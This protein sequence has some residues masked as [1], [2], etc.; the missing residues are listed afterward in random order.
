MKKYLVGSI[1]GAII[2]FIWQGLSYMAL[3]VHSNDM[4]YTS[5]QD[6]IMPVLTANLKEDGAYEMPSAATMKERN[7]MMKSM[8]GKP[9]ATIIYKS[10]VSTD[11]TMRYVRCILLDIFLVIS[12]IY[13]LT[14]GGTPIG[15]RVFSGS[16]A[17]GLATWLWTQYMG[18]IWFDLPWHMITGQLID[19]VV[20]W[21]LCGI[22][23]GWWLNRGRVQTA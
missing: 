19:S 3:G 11:M 5:A 15:R 16:V 22:W 21:A 8:D 12:L 7:D 17:F 6:Q 13:I 18:H 1:V 14:R 2:I 4:K 9:M 10:S 20:A 23:L